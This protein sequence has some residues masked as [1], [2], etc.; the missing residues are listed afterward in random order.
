MRRFR[1]CNIRAERRA[2]SVWNAF[3]LPHKACRFAEKIPVFRE[4]TGWTA[5]CRRLAVSLF[6]RR[7]SLKQQ[8]KTLSRII[9]IKILFAHPQ[10]CISAFIVINML[11][12]LFLFYKHSALARPCR[13]AAASLPRTLHSCNKKGRFLQNNRSTR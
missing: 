8:N 7:I 12:L 6:Q 13:I 1:G 3:H 10:Y 4:T 2:F 11:F 9:I 5:L